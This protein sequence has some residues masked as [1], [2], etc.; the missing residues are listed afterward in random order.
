MEQRGRTLAE[1]GPPGRAADTG[2]TEL[3]QELV[4]RVTLA[5]PV[6][7]WRMAGLPVSKASRRLRRKLVSC[8]ARGEKARS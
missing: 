6:R 2:R 1:D 5:N 4:L 8:A 7:Q 3:G